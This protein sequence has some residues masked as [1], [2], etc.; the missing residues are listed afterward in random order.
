MSSLSASL[1]SHCAKAP[2]LGAAPPHLPAPP[3]RLSRLTD[4]AFFFDLDGTLAP[5]AP[6]PDAARIPEDT[7]RLLERLKTATEGTVAIISGRPAD[8]IDQLTRPLQL[9]LSGLHGAQWRG[10]N[11]K[12]HQADVHPERLRLLREELR[13]IAAQH[14][15]TFVEDKGLSLAIHYRQAPEHETPIIQQTAQLAPRWQDCFEL[16]PGKMVIEFKPRGAN[17]GEAL[18]RFLQHH[19][20]LGKTPIMIGDDATDEPAFIAANQQHG[21][22][23]RIGPGPTQ[24]LFR[25][26]SPRALVRWLSSVLTN[27]NTRRASA[28]DS[29]NRTPDT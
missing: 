11:G 16:Q 6:T 9:P 22:S 18:K 24:A 15:G 28:Q 3:N 4:Y 17:K 13:T 12:L 8:Q 25:L 20:F 5:I 7:I 14:P 1:S 26:G 19:P 21:M 29:T 10:T 2:S 23:I 27:A